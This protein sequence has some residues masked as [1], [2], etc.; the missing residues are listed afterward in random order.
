MPNSEQENESGT[1]VPS[2][3]TELGTRI[4]EIESGF[5]NRE[6]AARAAG[7]AKST[8]QRWGDGTSDPSFEG[9]VRLAGAAE[10]SLDW[11]ATGIENP[12]NVLAQLGHNFIMVPRYDVEASTGPGALTAKENVVDYMAFQVEWAKRALDADPER[13]ALISAKGD[14]MEPTIRA[15][16]LLLVDTSVDRFLDDAIYVVVIDGRLL[17]KRAQLFMNGTIA[18]KSDNASYVEQIL[19]PDEAAG[20]V[21][22]GRVRWIGRLV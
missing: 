11:L 2:F 13:L 7:V 4:R 21:V 12:E 1:A 9:L 5:K 10:F 17:V 3:R 22:A 16:D 6:E 19:S 18:V 8:L 14:S 15:G 20:A